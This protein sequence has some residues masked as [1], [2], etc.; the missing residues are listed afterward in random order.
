MITSTFNNCACTAIADAK[1]FTGA[2]VGKELTARC[3]IEASVTEDHLTARVISSAG[4]H[5]SETSTAKAFADV[6]VGL[7]DQAHIHALHVEGTEALTC[8]PLEGEVELTVEPGVAMTCSDL[9]GQASADAAISV[10]DRHG[11]SQLTMALDGR[12]Q[13]GIG[14]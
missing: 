13:F 10:D 8:K 7:A 4:G 11:A 6:V 9:A 2:A 12:H 14:E 5:H 3:A 1:A